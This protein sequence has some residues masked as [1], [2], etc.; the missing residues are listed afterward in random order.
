M[1]VAEKPAAEATR[2]IKTEA[3]T[4]KGDHKLVDFLGLDPEQVV[5]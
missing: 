4:V 1:G 2:G 3:L 5:E